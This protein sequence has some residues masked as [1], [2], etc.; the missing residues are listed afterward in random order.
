MAA[1]AAPRKPDDLLP[2]IEP[3]EIG[4]RAL[5]A[6]F[7]VLDPAQH[8]HHFFGSTDQVRALIGIQRLND[9]RDGRGIRLPYV[10]RFSDPPTRHERPQLI[11]ALLQGTLIGIM[12]HK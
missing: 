4:H 5:P 12:P 9:R 1:L 11:S 8:V 10:I 6:L 7:Q 2:F 3:E